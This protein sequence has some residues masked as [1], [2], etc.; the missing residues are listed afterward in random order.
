MLQRLP[1][2]YKRHCSPIVPRSVI[3]SLPRM[4]RHCM[5]LLTCPN[6]ILVDCAPYYPAPRPPCPPPAAPLSYSYAVIAG[7]PHSAPARAHAAP[8]IDANRCQDPRQRGRPRVI[9]YASAPPDIRD[10]GA[11]DHGTHQSRWRER[12][13]GRRAGI[14]Q[15]ATGHPQSRRGV[16]VRLLNIVHCAKWTVGSGHRGSCGESRLA[17][18]SEL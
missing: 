2:L 5:I 10:S 9:C 3:S 15:F 6:P 18:V 16:W 14:W 17:R 13:L 8:T 12:W 1:S 4:P 7:Q 11:M